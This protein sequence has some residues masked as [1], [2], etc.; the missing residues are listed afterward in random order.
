MKKSNSTKRREF[1]RV[2]AA[3]GASVLVG[4]PALPVAAEG[5]VPLTPNDASA[6]ALAYVDDAST[7]PLAER[8]DAA[9]ACV[10]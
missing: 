10:N 2:G 5:L 4:L 8:K 3:A 9:N 6:K 1:L 7:V